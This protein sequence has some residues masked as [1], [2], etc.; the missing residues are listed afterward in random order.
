[1]SAGGEPR[2]RMAE[3]L[4]SATVDD[5]VASLLARGALDA[6]QGSVGFD[7]SQILSLPDEVT[8]SPDKG[9]QRTQTAAA[10]RKERARKRLA[11]EIEQ[12]RE[13]SRAAHRAADEAATTAA[14]LSQHAAAADAELAEAQQRLEGL[15]P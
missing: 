3:T 9:G 4:R 15:G 12:L 8:S 13:K 10:S 14:R 2:R 6:D 5:A 7:F 11:T 1:M